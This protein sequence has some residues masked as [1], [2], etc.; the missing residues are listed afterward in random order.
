MN[1]KE[2]PDYGS[3]PPS[4]PAFF[5]RSQSETIFSEH[6]SIAKEKHQ[7][8]NRQDVKTVY[9]TIAD[10]AI[11][12]SL[13]PLELRVYSLLYIPRIAKDLQNFESPLITQEIERIAS[14]L[15]KRKE[16]YKSWFEKP[17]VS[18]ILKRSVFREITDSQAKL[19][20]E[21]FHY[22]RSY[23]YES[24]HFGLLWEDQ[25]QSR[26]MAMAT[27][28]PFDLRH[29]EPLIVG[30]AEPSEVTVLSRV[31]AF[32]WAPRNTISYLLSRL[33]RHLRS[34]SPQT[35]LLLTYLNP[36]LGFTGA[37]YRAS[38]WILLAYESGTRYC[39][40]DG[41][42]IT[43]RELCR[44]FGT[45]DKNVLAQRLGRRFDVSTGF[46]KPLE[47]YAYFL[48]QSQQLF[49]QHAIQPVI[50]RPSDSCQGDGGNKGNLL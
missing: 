20:L 25:G 15:K 11:R 32:D 2:N 10:V 29:L 14:E 46:L 47:L 38:N 39:Y 45:S 42:Y 33:I 41:T 27:L 19:V 1:A 30:K 9:K 28:S 17:I 7:S 4:Q 12:H 24:Q 43:D 50:E 5:D 26:L 18:P 44:K 48:S 22:L 13:N 21:N 31:F 40:L 34:T 8:L 6:E 36:N 23:R 35:R 16:L 49:K 37:S 3:S